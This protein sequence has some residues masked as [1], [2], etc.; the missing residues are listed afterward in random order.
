MS[1][2][3][4]KNGKIATQL[5]NAVLNSI[6]NVVPIEFQQ[7]KPKLMDANLKMKYGVLIGMTG[8]VKGQLILMGEPEVFAKIGETMFGM[9]I[10]GEMLSSFSGELG[11][12]VAGG[13]STNISSEGV[14]TDITS[15]TI[16][17]GNAMLSGHKRGLEIPIEFKDTGKM[18][19]FLLLD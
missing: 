1:N 9:P 6:K 3:N 12:M 8:D 18:G 13:M 16:M 19:I 10:E 5:L 14:T 17:Q 2:S 15:P 4:A 7:D 11:N